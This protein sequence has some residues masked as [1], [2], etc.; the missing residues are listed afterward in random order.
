LTS[1]FFQWQMKKWTRNCHT[2]VVD[3]SGQRG[4]AELCAHLGCSSLYDLS[5][6]YIHDQGSKGLSEFTL[7]TIGVTLPANATKYREA[8]RD[9]DLRDAPSDPS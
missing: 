9:K 7:Q 2:G 4:R 5:V 8:V 1:I 6:R 3:Q